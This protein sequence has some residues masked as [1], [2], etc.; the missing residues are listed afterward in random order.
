MAQSWLK[1]INSVLSVITWPCNRDPVRAGV[2]AR[3]TI[4]FAQSESVIVCAGYR[5]LCAFF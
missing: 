5:L 3:I 4:S 1:N 2:F